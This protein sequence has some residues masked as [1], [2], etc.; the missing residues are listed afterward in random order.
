MF[1]IL[2]LTQTRKIER[3]IPIVLY[4]RAYWNE[5]IDFRALVRHGAVS[6]ADLDLFS[7]AD[8]P[9]EALKLLQAKL[10]KH[11][12]PTTPAFAKS[13]TPPKPPAPLSRP[14]SRGRRAPRT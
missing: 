14:A 12:E 10:P 2:T 3:A 5:V 13:R 6:R 8:T 11:V 1:E 4:G 9:R 7:F